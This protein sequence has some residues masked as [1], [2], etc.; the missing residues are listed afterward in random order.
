MLQ[1]VVFFPRQLLKNGRKSTFLVRY[2]NIARR[3]AYLGARARARDRIRSLLEDDQG[4]GQ[5][6]KQKS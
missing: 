1:P 3:M 4:H 2:V 6:T 5:T